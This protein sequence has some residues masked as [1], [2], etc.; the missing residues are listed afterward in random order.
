MTSK[1]I[2]QIQD[3]TEMSN[4]TEINFGNYQNE[5][6]VINRIGNDNN[7]QDEK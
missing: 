3:R 2:K 5:Y 7:G 6:E 4:I 1:I